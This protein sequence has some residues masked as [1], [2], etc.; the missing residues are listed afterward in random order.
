MEFKQDHFPERSQAESETGEKKM[1]Q[2]G[3]THLPSDLDQ[4]SVSVKKNIRSP[5]IEISNPVPQQV[6]TAAS[7]LEL[8]D[9]TIGER[10]R[11]LGRFV[12][13]LFFTQ[14]L[15]ELVIRV[16]VEGSFITIGL[17]L[18]PLFCLIRSLMM[19]AIISILPPRGKS[20]MFIFLLI[21]FPF[22]YSAQ[23]VYYK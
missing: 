3:V 12:C 5:H 14:L 23:L 13:L 11:C 10:F 2:D 21:L 22:L 16:N 1:P 8:R 7:L 17:L 6:G 18:I 20:F 15:C 9:G 19:A 4:Q